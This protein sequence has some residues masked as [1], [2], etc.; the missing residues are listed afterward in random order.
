M[1][2]IIRN[3]QSS[4][5]HTSL[6]PQDWSAFRAL[7]HRMLDET[8]DGIA[9][10]RTRP[11]WQPIPDDVRA[12]FKADVPREASDLAEVYREFTEHVA[13]YATG[14]VHPGFMGWVHGGGTAVGMLADML[15]AGLNANLGGRDHMP[16]EVERQ[17]VDWMRRLF[18]FPDSA[19][20]IFVTGTSMANLMAVLVA[21]N[22][23]LGTLARQYGIGNGGVLLTAYTSQAAHGCVSRAMDIAGLGTDA[24]R[25]IGVDA[26]HRIDVEALRAQ[27]AVDREVG[28]KPFL[29]VAS[30]GTVDIGAIDDLKA[31]AQL[32]REEGI[33]FHVDGAFGALAIFS[34]ELAPLL[35]GIELADS[36]ALDFH[37][38]GQVPYD[39]GF[40]LVRDGEQHRQAFAQPAAYLRREA[41]GLAAG[42][43]W[44]CD[45]GPDLSRGF[46]A[47]K[48]W[49]TLKTFGTERLGA[50][51]AR[52]CALAKYLEARILAEPRL[53]L[54]A[55]VNLN[56]VC[57]R[58]RADDAINREIV[59]DIQEFGIAAP[60]ST[61]LDGK[62]AIRA[63]IVNHRSDERDVDA[64]V[65]AVLEFGARRTGEGL[66]E[67]EAP[68]LAAQ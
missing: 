3:A 51:I 13:P 29:V 61:T 11:V 24:L 12:A 41:R 15:A 64:L 32:C 1:N 25:K 47:L 59:A 45:L 63:A 14:N 54:L 30:A 36:I 7:A 2:E 52:S 27:I 4:V 40:L 33:W 34:P 57:F 44:P 38:W 68:S 8:I 35:G 17:I 19:S 20:G 6:D 10:V 58:Y 60:S 55:P 43:V 48:T 50:T 18:A 56:I 67:V 28:F 46:R 5:A 23:A 66:I 42:A 53:E 9:N 31:V 26:D 22:V 39:A 62:F 37:K 49:F 65:A 21:R 16:I